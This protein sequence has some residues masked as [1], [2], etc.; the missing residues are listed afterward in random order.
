[1]YSWK[2]QIKLL[3]LVVSKKNNSPNAPIL[4]DNQGQIIC[5]AHPTKNP[6]PIF[7]KKLFSKIKIIIS[8]CFRIKFV[9]NLLQNG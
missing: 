5:G 6:K 7:Q 8:A 3:K 2:F 9:P 1:L 4:L